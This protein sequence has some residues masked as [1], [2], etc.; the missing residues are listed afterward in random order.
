M[1]ELSNVVCLSHFDVNSTVNKDHSALPS[2]CISHDS[3]SVL[4]ILL[5]FSFTNN[6]GSIYLTVPS[7]RSEVSIS[8]PFRVVEA[9]HIIRVGCIKGAINLWKF[10]YHTTT[11]SRTIAD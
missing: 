1:E 7:G 11:A 4:G 10:T 5:S 6:V 3:Q 9:K 2:A 8:T